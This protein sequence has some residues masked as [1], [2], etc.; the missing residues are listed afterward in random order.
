MPWTCP[1]CGNRVR[2]DG[3]GEKPPKSG[4]VYRCHVCR[5]ELVFDPRVNKMRPMP[6]P[7]D[8][9]ESDAA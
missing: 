1:A 5:I 4:V 7:P 2:H 6:L 9:K 8:P 3:N